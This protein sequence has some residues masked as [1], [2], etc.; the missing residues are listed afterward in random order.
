V[1]DV[2]ESSHQL[3]AAMER[4][5]SD[6]AA[7]LTSAADRATSAASSSSDM[8]T[9]ASQAAAEARRSA[10]DA[11]EAVRRGADSITEAARSNAGEIR[12]AAAAA[13]QS[14][15]ETAASAKEDLRQE[16][17]VL[18]ERMR[19]DVAAQAQS[20]LD[21]LHATAGAGQEAVA[22][23]QMAA[24]EARTAAIDSQ[25]HAERAQEAV[26][27]AAGIGAQEVL[28]RLEVDYELITRLVQELHNRITSLT[29]QAPAPQPALAAVPPGV[30]QAAYE[31]PAEEAIAAEPPPWYQE[32]VEEATSTLEPDY[33]EPVAE[34]RPEQ[35]HEDRFAGRVLVTIAPVPDFDRLLNL[36]GALGRMS[37]IA[38][39][40]LADYAKEEVTFRL[41][42]ERPMSADDFARSLSESAGSEACV[43]AA[44]DGKLALRLV[45]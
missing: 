5:A 20:L 19:D 12:D 8:A 45:S 31:A 2:S 6:S 34:P 24:M 40:S 43:A 14:I 21:Q 33:D 3:V 10:E 25:A 4:F 44:T 37:G 42:V 9:A 26:S 18:G 13:I 11:G 23:A 28:E 38:N 35:A 41:E 15:N 39:V 16:A 27:P 36:D 29:N 7:M 1:S 32:A 17:R 30:A 22:A